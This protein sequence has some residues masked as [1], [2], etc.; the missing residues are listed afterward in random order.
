MV[1]EL[2]GLSHEMDL[3]FEDMH[4]WSALGLKRVYG[5]V[6]IFLEYS[7]GLETSGVP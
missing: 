7:N 1:V 3:A 4:A 6:K 2:K 5:K